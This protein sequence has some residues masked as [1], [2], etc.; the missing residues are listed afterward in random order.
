MT[1]TSA[2]V[3]EWNVSTWGYKGAVH[4]ACKVT[5]EAGE[6]ADAAIKRDE[7]RSGDWTRNLLDEMADTVIALH[8][9][10]AKEGVE[11]YDLVDERFYED[12]MHRKRS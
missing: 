9:L 10:A 3:G 5:A 6:V 11:L 4:R 2:E 8:S 12:V 7:G 1:L